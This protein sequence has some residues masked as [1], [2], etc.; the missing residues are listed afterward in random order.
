MATIAVRGADR[1]YGDAARVGD[2]SY[3][4]LCGVAR[5]GAA[6]IARMATT[7]LRNDSDAM[8]CTRVVLCLQIVPSVLR[9]LWWY[10]ERRMW[11]Q[12]TE[13]MSVEVG[14]TKAPGKQIYQ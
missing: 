7:I 4:D 1:Y 11:W 14:A 5:R 9:C 3:G 10:H 8:Q 2:R 13:A 12:A 6:R